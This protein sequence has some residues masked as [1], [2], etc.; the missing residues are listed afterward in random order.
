MKILGI[1]AFYHDSAAALVCDGHVMGAVQEERFSRKKHDSGFPINAIQY[2][3]KEVGITTKDIDCIVFYEKLDLKLQRIVESFIYFGPGHRKTFMNVMEVQIKKRQWLYSF[4]RKGLKYKGKIQFIKH[5]ESHA[6][7][8]FYPSPFTSSAYL[9]VD[10]VGEW[11]TTTYGVGRWHQIELYKRIN[12]PHSLGLLYAAFTYFVGFKVNSGEYK[13]MGLAPYGSPKYANKILD[14][15]IDLK[16]DGSFQLNMK[17]FDFVLGDKM[18]N[19]RFG[20]LFGRTRR[21]PESDISQDDMD[22]ARSIQEVTEIAM[23]RLARHVRKQTREKNLCMAGGVSLNCVANGKILKERI[24]DNIWIQPAGGDAGAALGAALYIWHQTLGNQRHVSSEMDGQN[25]YFLGPKYDKHDIQEFLELNNIVYEYCSDIEDRT[26]DLI[27]QN[28]IVGWFSGRMEFGPR[29]LGGRS[30]LGDP[31]QP[32]MQKKMNLK[33]KYRES[34][35]PFAP[36]VLEDKAKD[37]FEL[38]QSSPFM[39]LVAG[40]KEDKRKILSKEQEQLFG[41][42]K[43]NVIRSDIHAVTHVDYSARVQTVSKERNKKFYGLIKNV[44][45]KTGCPVVINTSFNVRGE[46]IVCTPEDAYRCFIRTEM[47]FLVLENYLIDK[48]SQRGFKEDTSWQTEYV[49]D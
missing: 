48:K 45:K 32:D 42:D 36:S 47:D 40:V 20:K 31:R 17:Y 27:A 15:L 7:S 44:L 3:C 49:L 34:F 39:L 6:A 5:H 37:W 13:L 38:D 18:I 8:A 25:N 10:G 26:A 19:D 22:L 30:I 24:F 28:N 16:E 21:R 4:I 46:P 41:I 11:E 1:S 9:T 2:L 14:E 35:R 33:I 43:L 29:A 12:F 23:L